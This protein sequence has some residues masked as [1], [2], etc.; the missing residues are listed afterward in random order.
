MKENEW[1]LI[2]IPTTSDPEHR[3]IAR[4]KIASDISFKTT[5]KPLV[6]TYSGGKDS[7]VI[8]ELARR[9]G[10]PFEVWHNHTTADAPET[11]Y[12][13]RAEM[14]RLEN[15]GIP[16]G[17]QYPTYKGART[18][19]WSLIVHKLMPPTR[20]ARYCCAVLKEQSGADRM[21]ATGVRWDE[22]TNRARKRGIFERQVSNPEKQ[23]KTRTDDENLQ[24][25]YEPCKLKA[26]RIVNPIIDWTEQEVWDFLHDARVPIN[27]LYD[28]GMRRVGCVGCP[29]AG[30]RRYEE[31]R[32]WPDYEK[33]YVMAFD[34]MIQ[35]RTRRGKTSG[36]WRCGKTGQEI[37]QWWM[38]ENVLPGQMSI[39][40]YQK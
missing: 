35:E 28:C 37:F 2:T 24:A 19:M 33:L 38:E 23:I 8:L 25:L 39:E 14:A 9:G 5:G 13:V 16:A 26:K 31:F 34:R 21:I 30:K 27:P 29:M 22:S 17:I 18:S 15:M 6:V 32:R 20:R 10:I 7:S 12:F 1:G 36:E 3:A 4:L 40:D 11:V